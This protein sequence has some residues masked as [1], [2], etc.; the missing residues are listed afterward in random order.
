MELDFLIIESKAL[1]TAIRI[2]QVEGLRLVDV[3]NSLDTIDPKSS[4]LFVLYRNILK[5]DVTNLLTTISNP[6][7]TLSLHAPLTLL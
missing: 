6:A 4:H 3:L 5:S 2:P 7:L 1:L